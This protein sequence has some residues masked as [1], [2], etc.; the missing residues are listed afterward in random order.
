L[1]GKTPF[2]GE[3][4]AE[5]MM[6]ILQEEP[7]ELRPEGVVSPQSLARLV[8]RALEKEPAD[9][10]QSAREFGDAVR[11]HLRAQDSSVAPTEV[12]TRAELAAAVAPA[13]EAPATVRARLAAASSVRTT[14]RAY[15][16][17]SGARRG[18]LLPAMI[19]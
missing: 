2:E 18:K 9:R 12:R 13:L 10:Y 8:K 17:P 1:A 4:T 15:P 14:P 16:E 6:K 11:D 5:T 3:S 19:T 7:P